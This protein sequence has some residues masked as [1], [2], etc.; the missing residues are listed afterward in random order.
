METDRPIPSPADT[1]GDA[2]GRDDR[3]TAHPLPF[4][5]A[6]KVLVGAR[7]DKGGDGD[8]GRA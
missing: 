1:S 5:D 4:L 8:D 7:R 6:V 3:L 2:L